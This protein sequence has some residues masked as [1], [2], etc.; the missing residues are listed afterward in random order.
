MR[1]SACHTCQRYVI[2][3]A[4]TISVTKKKVIIKEVERDE[5]IAKSIHIVQA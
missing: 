3:T 2:G 5:I 1:D 4:E